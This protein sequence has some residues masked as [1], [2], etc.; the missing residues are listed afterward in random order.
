LNRD[1]QFESNLEA[2]QVP[3]K[4]IQWVV[5]PLQNTQY[6]GRLSRGLLLVAAEHS[7]QSS[8]DVVVGLWLSDR[9][10]GQSDDTG[11]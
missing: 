9:R 3:A 5:L 2:L 10:H 6:S 11:R 1:V 7:R 4:Y 8:R